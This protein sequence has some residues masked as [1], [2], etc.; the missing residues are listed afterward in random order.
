MDKEKPLARVEPEGNGD[1]FTAPVAFIYRGSENEG[2]CGVPNEP[3]EYAVAVDRFLAAARISE[4]SRRVYRVALET[5]GWLLVGRI[6]P[7]GDERRGARSPVVLLGR[8]DGAGAAET[9]REALESRALMVD[10]RTLAREASILRNAAH[11]WAAR[12]WIRPEAEAAIRAFRPRAAQD[13]DAGR[14]AAVPGPLDAAAVFRLSAPLREQSLWRLLY[15]SAAPVEH[16]LA[17]DTSDLDFAGRR[18]RRRAGPRAA[19]RIGW[20]PLSAQVLPLLTIGRATGPVFLTERRAA[21]RVPAA[22]RCPYTRR[23]RLSARRAAE[24]FQTAT[25]EIDP[26]GTGWTLRDLRLEGRRIRTRSS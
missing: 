5:W 23:A 15:E 7:T 2:A 13:P 19:D 12:G 21:A 22:D 9:I 3:V 24:L 1:L 14:E 17:L 26:A 4:P 16:L 8:L 6:P 18:V 10:P 11:W 20:G 25:R